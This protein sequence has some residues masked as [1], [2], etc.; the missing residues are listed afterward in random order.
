MKKFKQYYFLPFVGLGSIAIFG[1]YQNAGSIDLTLG[2]F[3]IFIGL[4][5]PFIVGLIRDRFDHK[6]TPQIRKKA[7]ANH[8]YT[9]LID[10]GFE[11]KDHVYLE[12]I[13]DGY[14]VFVIHDRRLTIGVSLL[15]FFHPQQIDD[16]HYNAFL[17][18]IV[19]SKFEMSILGNLLTKV[20]CGLKP[21]EIDAIQSRLN[22]GVDF[23]KKHGYQPIDPLELKRLYEKRGR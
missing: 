12:G 13:V 22:E 4:I 10:M 7:Y 8:P 3:L 2:L 1:W 9:D 16:A 6:W 19:K 11:M 15:F 5:L 23:L 20:E 17:K 21:C 14:S 18:K